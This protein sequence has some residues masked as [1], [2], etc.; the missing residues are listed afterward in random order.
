MGLITRAIGGSDPQNPPLGYAIANQY[1]Y[2][3]FLSDD[4]EATTV[5]LKSNISGC[6]IDC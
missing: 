4:R 3:L 6:L 2:P 5:Q 1:K